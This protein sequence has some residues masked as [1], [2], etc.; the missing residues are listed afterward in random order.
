MIGGVFLSEPG[1]LGP[2]RK[3]T[4]AQFVIEGQSYTATQIATRLGVSDSAARKRLAREQA[5]PCPVTWAGLRADRRTPPPLVT[6]AKSHPWM[7]VPSV[8]SKS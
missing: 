7:R 3:H 1:E 4:K 5:L 2:H 8:R 6:P